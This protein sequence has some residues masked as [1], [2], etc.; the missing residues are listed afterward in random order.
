MFGESTLDEYIYNIISQK[1]NVVSNIID[2]KF[3]KSMNYMN[4][5]FESENKPIENNGLFYWTSKR[6]SLEEMV[7]EAIEEKLYGDLG[8]RDLIREII[9]TEIHAEKEQIEVMEKEK[10]KEIEKET[11]GKK[12]GI[13]QYFEKKDADDKTKK[14]KILEDYYKRYPNKK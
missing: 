4:Q 7:D 2:G 5:E 8:D 1:F 9:E 14:L 6:I 11:R 3:D 10:K 13:A 12:F